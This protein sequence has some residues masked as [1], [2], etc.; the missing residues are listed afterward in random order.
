M[1]N[2]FAV[3]IFLFSVALW[4]QE[5]NSLLVSKNTF[6]FRDGYLISNPFHSIYDTNGWLWVLGENKLSNEYILGEQEIIIQRFDGVNFFTLKLPDTFNKKIIEG[7]FFKSQD[8]GLYLKLYYQAAR[9]ELFYINT[10][11]LALKAVKEYNNLNENF[12][13]SKA[14][15]AE[16]SSRIILTT[17]NKFYSAKL[18]KLSLR[19]IDS[20]PF[21][22]PVAQ[23]V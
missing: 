7:H 5:D 21:E 22:K 12:L 11:T 23:P 4:C 9:A 13:F 19:F 6:S 18:D 17:N 1:K 8:H 15:T 14:Y 10:E 2:L 20:I 16:D 3:F